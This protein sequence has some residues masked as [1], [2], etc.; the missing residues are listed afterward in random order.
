MQICLY[1]SGSLIDIF[2]VI[3]VGDKK[4]NKWELISERAGYKYSV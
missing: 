4:Q 3:Y 2:L 1:I